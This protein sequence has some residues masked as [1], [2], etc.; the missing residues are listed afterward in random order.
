M[1]ENTASSTAEIYQLHTKPNRGVGDTSVLLAEANHRIA[2]NLAAVVGLVRME[3]TAIGTKETM[4]GSDVR[5]LLEEIASRVDAV[6]TLHKMLAQQPLQDAVDI[7][8]Y[9]GRVCAPLTSSLFGAQ[10]FGLT[11]KFAP[12]C[13]VPRDQVVSIA[14][15]VNEL[16]TNASKYAHPA[17]VPG[18]V[19]VTCQRDAKGNLVLEVAD[20]GVGL[21][22]GFDPQTDGNV[23]LRLVR[24]LCTQMDADLRFDSSSLGLRVRIALP[25]SGR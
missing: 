8:D 11:Q 7:G 19:S 22:E 23:G 14:L 24:I 13:L 21:P 12:G 6:G 3:A 15:I 16:V 5:A 17:G 10:Q 1:T 18:K 4:T 20:D 2:N 25:L 9:L